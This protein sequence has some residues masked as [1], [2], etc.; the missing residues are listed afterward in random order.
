MLD[1][2]DAPAPEVIRV[3]I[4]AQAQGIPVAD[5]RLDTKLTLKGPQRRVGVQGPS[6]SEIAGSLQSLIRND[7]H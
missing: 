3:A 5:R 1:L 2:R 7:D 6:S 4:L